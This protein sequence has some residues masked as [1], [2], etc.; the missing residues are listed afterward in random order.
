MPRQGSGFRVQCAIAGNLS[1]R[2]D[3]SSWVEIARYS[4]SLVLARI[5]L[6]RAVSTRCAH[7][8]DLS[9]PA[10]V[11]DGGRGRGG[12]SPRLS[13]PASAGLWLELLVIVPAG[14]V[15]NY[16]PRWGDFEVQQVQQNHKRPCL[17]EVSEFLKVQQKCNM[18][19]N[20]VQQGAVQHGVQ[21]RQRKSS[22]FSGNI[23]ACACLRGAAAVTAPPAINN[24]LKRFK[25][26]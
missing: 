10:G 20:K 9:R 6:S 11:V 17:Q 25:I 13:E 19:C 3:R 22:V 2:R 4:S 15:P 23:Q 24:T 1:F 8:I 12:A 14:R 26:V 5:E 7:E 16:S 21:Q 18:K